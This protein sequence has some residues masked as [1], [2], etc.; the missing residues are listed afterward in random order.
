[1]TKMTAEVRVSRNGRIH[2][3]LLPKTRAQ[4]QAVGRVRRYHYSLPCAAIRGTTYYM[5]IL[6][7]NAR[8]EGPDGRPKATQG[9]PS[10]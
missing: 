7:G 1:M 5:L 4:K 6:D 2:L 3:T 10:K 9:G 8:A